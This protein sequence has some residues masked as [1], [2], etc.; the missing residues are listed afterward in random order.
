MKPRI[1]LTPRILHEDGYDHQYFNQDYVLRLEGLGCEVV[2][3]LIHGDVKKLARECDG[4]IVTGGADIDPKYYNQEN[5]HSKNIRQE[6]DESD[7]RIIQ[8]FVDEDK[9][10]LGI[11]R[12]IQSLNVFFKGSLIQ[13]LPSAGFNEHSIRRRFETVHSVNIKKDSV[14]GSLFGEKLEVNSLHHQAIDRPAEGFTITAMSEDGVIE[15]FEKD[16]I[17]AVQWHPECI[18]AHKPLFEYFVDQCMKNRD[19]K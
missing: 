5:V 3:I 9:P 10:I 6:V 12:G 17:I 16:K 13:D 14:L 15:A 11:C 4:V 7:F 1:A 19:N 18:E 2:P 8:A